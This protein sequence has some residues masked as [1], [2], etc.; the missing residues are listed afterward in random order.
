MLDFSPLTY[1]DQCRLTYFKWRYVL[2]ADGF[3]R[4]EALRL[5]FCRTLALAGRYADDG[6]PPAALVARVGEE[7]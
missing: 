1:T 5:I 3:T 7:A 2:Q 4:A 6:G